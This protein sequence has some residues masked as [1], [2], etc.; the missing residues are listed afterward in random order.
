MLAKDGPFPRS[1]QNT[2]ILR[3][4]VRPTSA[5]NAILPIFSGHIDRKAQANLR[6]LL[7]SATPKYVSAQPEWPVAVAQT[8]RLAILFGVGVRRF[9]NGVPVEPLP[10][11]TPKVGGRSGTNSVT[12]SPRPWDPRPAGRV[13][14]AVTG[15]DGTGLAC[16]E[17]SRPGARVGERAATIIGLWYPRG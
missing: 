4:S 17:G 15:L 12:G 5:R 3:A 9:P 7:R 6:N 10:L 14:P 8:E 13:R 16:G 2:L 1:G 11:G